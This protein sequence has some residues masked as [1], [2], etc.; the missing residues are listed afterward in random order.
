MSPPR[1]SHS[2]L[3]ARLFEQVGHASSLEEVYAAT[4]ECLRAGL[5][6]KRAA[7][8][9]LDEQRVMKFQAWAQLSDAYMAAVEGHSPWDAGA[10]EFSAIAVTD[11]RVDGAL[12]SFREVFKQE[13]IRA[14]AF[15][16][17]VYAGRLLG[18]FMLY[19]EE[20]HRFSSEELE[21]AGAVATSIGFALER[22]RIEAEL[23]SRVALESAVRAQ[24]EQSDRRLRLALS[25]GNMG[26]W[27]WEISTGTVVWSPELEALHGLPPG[28]FGGR[29]DDFRADAH[30]DDAARVEAAI[31][32]TLQERRSD[33]S[34]EYRIIRQ[35]GELRW[36]AAQ[37]KLF[38][39][40]R[41]QPARLVGVCS[42]ITERRL[43]SE[44][45][46][47]LAD[48]GRS[49]VSA[50]DPTVT[51]S[52][53]ARLAVQGVADWCIIFADNGEGLSLV[54]MSQ[55]HP[56]MV[57]RAREMGLKWPMSSMEGS[58]TLKVLR[59]GKPI[60]LGEV[61]PTLARIAV[62]EEHAQA[63]KEFG[64]YSALVLP[65]QVARS[66]VGVVVLISAESRRKYAERDLAPA[67]E[68]A[69]RAASAFESARL[70]QAA[71]A[72]QRAAET[73][74]R[75]VRILLE[76]NDAL[77]SSLDPALTLT[78]LAD[79]LASRMAD[80]VV[81]YTVEQRC[82]RRSAVAGCDEETRAL[83]AKLKDLPPP[84]IEDKT[85]A[86]AVIESGEPLL[87]THVDEELLGRVLQNDEHLGIVRA[88]Q[89]RSSLIVP[90]R[91]RGRTL[92][93][94]ALSL[95]S[96][97]CQR[98][99]ESD[100]P[101]VQELA[102]RAAL[103]LD[104]TNLYHRAK[105]AIAARDDVLTVVA[106]D[107]RNPLNTIA[108]AVQLLEIE[109]VEDKRDRAHQILR[110]SSEQM[111]RLV[112]DL[113]DFASLDD[114][115]MRVEFGDVCPRSLAFEVVEQFAALATD[116]R[117][118]LCVEAPPHIRS[119]AADGHRLAQVVSNL[120]GNAL[121]HTGPGGRV[122]VRL[123][124]TADSARYEV[125]DTGPGIPEDHQPHV[126]TRFW[127][128]PNQSEKGFGLGLAIAKGIVEAHGGTI[129]LESQPGSGCRFFFEV[130]SEPPEACGS[131]DSQTRP[132]VRL[133]QPEVASTRYGSG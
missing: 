104:N 48:A 79:F 44:W 46:N 123:F 131:A 18:K 97:S 74:A 52:E 25:A 115:R 117:I 36:V 40:E 82:V 126:F 76:A 60:L 99:E 130:P 24:Q 2:V 77:A 87:A 53:L 75:Q 4:F 28:G 12:A 132:A 80:Y 54:E 57:K 133:P 6:V 13:K 3:L 16:P 89:P 33:Y 63:L 111:T 98:Y 118:D 21:F 73:A 32:E 9:L 27:E 1:N 37:G 81:V 125:I 42:D 11:V 116:R 31:R 58:V 39:D 91:T 85:G 65:L 103:V 72:A 121:K 127:K 61:G 5:N 114:G 41:G 110:R 86:G 70:Y 38:L 120:V 20:V 22:L 109:R 35:D 10:T 88:L 23:R 43:A 107:L 106:H 122:V 69:N 108:T 62:N 90:L 71:R 66:T 19:H 83:A 100:V 7:V 51:L 68:F 29:F 113:M 56:E 129:G 8:L 49:L 112:Q 95:T 59:T 67:L 94:V 15:V 34:V 47:F 92:G 17:V 96:R 30:P 55:R 124:S 64:F 45:Q 128:A 93:A 101:L 119:I 102:D 14:L 84:S 50:L 78:R 26:T 105:A